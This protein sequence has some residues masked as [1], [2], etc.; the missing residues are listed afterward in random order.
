MKDTTGDDGFRVNSRKDGHLCGGRRIN[1]SKKAEQRVTRNNP[2][3]GATRPYETSSFGESVRGFRPEIRV[4]AGQASKLPGIEGA[5]RRRACGPAKI[6]AGE[7]AKGH[8]PNFLGVVQY[9]QP[10]P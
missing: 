10:G 1:L 2:C 3:E 4:N 8:G 9:P 7:I 6:R 5:M